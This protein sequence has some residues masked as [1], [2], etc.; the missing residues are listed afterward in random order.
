MTVNDRHLGENVSRAYRYF[1]M[2]KSY[3]PDILVLPELWCCGY[4]D[5]YTR[6]AMVDALNTMKRVSKHLDTLVVG[7]IPWIEEG[8][9]V[10]NRALAVYRGEVIAYYDKIHLFKPFNEHLIFK[11]GSYPALFSY[12]G[13]I[14]GLAI[15]YD[16]RFPELFRSYAVNGA[17]LV[18]APS[19][20]GRP[21]LH[22]WKSIVVAEAAINQ[23]FLV[24]VNRVGSSTMG[25]EFA[26]HSMAVDPW[27]DV[28]VELGEDESL[29]LADIDTGIVEPVRRRLPI[30][31]DFKE[32]KELK[33]YSNI[34]RFSGA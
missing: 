13:L 23:L 5:S 3:K 15:C 26:G 8:D 1:S 30:L 4:S 22:Q 9:F 2:V 33:V 18:I 14:V 31:E 12:K 24:A 28:I 7:S 34:R 27:G 20:W 16:M 11:P 6:R 10:Y 21:R 32:K 25:E 29:L 19:A 17:Q